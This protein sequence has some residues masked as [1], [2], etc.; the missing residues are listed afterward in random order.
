MQENNQLAMNEI[1]S[2]KN[3]FKKSEKYV[4]KCIRSFET[5]VGRIAID[6]DRLNGDTTS[7]CEALA[8]GLQEVRTGVAGQKHALNEVMSRGKQ[9]QQQPYFQQQYEYENRKNY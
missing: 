6:F 4:N 1:S 5:K 9:Q 8:S 3:S 7:V 2:F